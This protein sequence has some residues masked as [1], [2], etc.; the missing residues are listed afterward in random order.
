M[1]EIKKIDVSVERRLLGN[2]IMSTRL[3]SA[4]QD[5]ADPTLFESRLSRIVGGWVWDYYKK[6]GEAP[7]SSISD[8]YVQRCGELEDADSAMVSEFLRS[9][10]DEWKP[11]NEKYSE[12]M[13]LRYFRRRSVKRLSDELA[14]VAD[15]DDPAIAEKLVADYVKPDVHQSSGVS[16]L[17]AADSSKI[18]YAF[19]NEEEALFNFPDELGYVVG[20]FIVG[21]FIVFIAPP[22]RG[23]TWWLISTAINALLQGC[24]VLFVSLEMSEEQMVRRFWQYLSGC[25]RNGE[26]VALPY[27]E[28]TEDGRSTIVDSE[29]ETAKID[30]SS[31]AIKKIQQKVSMLSRGARIKLVNH[32]TG[33]YSV[34]D[35]RAELKN[36]EVYEN[37][38]PNVI[39]LDYADIMRHSSGD[40]ERS[41]I[42]ETYKALRG[43]ASERKCVLATASQTGRETV[44]GMKDAREGNV[45]EDIRKVAH[46]TKMITINQNEKEAERNLYRISCATTRDGAVVHDQVVCTSCLAIGRPF[47]ET[48]LLSRIDAVSADEAESVV[49]SRFSRRG[50]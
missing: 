47:I 8:I 37:F 44:G 21:D 22:K 3:L 5:I 20:D 18:A 45:S 46:C 33:T 43:L 24:N 31:Q 16:L 48:R 13:A 2:L 25:S 23:K 26:T 41:R 27:F 39:V 35:L 32:P 50:R 49:S 12:E 15:N 7:S 40:D 14:R 30:T 28:D 10:S 36:L 42:N 38:V 9:A 19:D 4:V 17:D 34:R 1:V 11:T 29:V 6:T